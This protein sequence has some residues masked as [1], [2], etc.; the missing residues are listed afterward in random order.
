VIN[1]VRSELRKTLST[2]VWFW[3]LLLSLA[4]TGLFTWGSTTELNHTDSSTTV[5]DIFTQGSS[6][7]L[8]L[9]V[10]GVLSVTTEFRYQTITPTLLATPGRAKLVLGKAIATLV[11]AAGYAIAC[12]IVNIA[13]GVPLISSKHIEYSLTENGIPGAMFGVFLTLTLYGLIGLGFGALVRNQV[14]GVVVGVIFI[15]ILQN[16]VLIVPGVRHVF[17]YLPGGAAS[18]VLT[19]K[20]HV[21]DNINLLG[22]Y[23]GLLVL[24]LWAAITAA[25]G[26]SFTLN[27]DIT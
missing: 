5:H 9:F 23:A 25:A 27:R 3:L 26:A 21:V 18:A 15:L 10:L 8:A 17:P 19:P 6:A 11:L 13:V 16:L 7:Q 24:F 20:E 2:Q 22:T 4:L 12:L 1:L 14:V